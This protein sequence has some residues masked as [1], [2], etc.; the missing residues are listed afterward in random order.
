MAASHHA[1][2]ALQEHIY[3]SCLLLGGTLATFVPGLGSLAEDLEAV[4]GEGGGVQM[5]GNVH[6]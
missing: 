1:Q 6:K 5:T 2:P 4:G 3:P